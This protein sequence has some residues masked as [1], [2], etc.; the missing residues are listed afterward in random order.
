MGN[1]ADAEKAATMAVSLD[2]KQADA[3][4]MLARVYAAERRSDDAVSEARAALAIVANLASAKLNAADA[5]AQKGDLDFAGA[6]LET[7]Y[8]VINGTVCARGPGLGI[9]WNEDAISRYVVQ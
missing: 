6:I 5:L 2:S 7:A 9:V 1:L 8:P 3:H 4:V